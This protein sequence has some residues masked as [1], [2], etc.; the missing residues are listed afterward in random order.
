MITT[1]DTPAELDE[2]FG[3][4]DIVAGRMPE[5]PF[6]QVPNWVLIADGIKPQAQALYAHLAMHVNSQ[7][8]DKKVWPTQ[9]VLAA[10]LKLNRVQSLTPYLEQLEELGAIDMQI[11]RYAGKMRQRYKYTVHFLPPEGYAGP[12]TQAEWYDAYWAREEEEKAR[13]ESATEEQGKSAHPS[14]AG[15]SGQTKQPKKSKAAGTGATKPAAAKKPLVARTK[16]PKSEEEQVLDTKAT[17]GAEWW[18]GER[19]TKQNPDPKPGRVETLVAEGK[20]PRYVGN[21][22][23]AYHAVRTMIRNAL[24]AG[25]DAGTIAKALEN[26]GRAFPSQQQFEDACARAAGVP[27]DRARTGASGRAPSYDDDATWGARKRQKAALPDPHP[28]QPGDED[29]F[30]L[31]DLADSA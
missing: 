2:V 23:S 28:D 24:K 16:P 11:S 31:R 10:R 21:K 13:K 9:R 30:G 15:G 8:G 22:S 4:V 5:V 26:G 1:D 12:V 19:K 3:D 27:V 20:M 18:W 7:R 17:R 25:Y 6:T 29:E 14:P